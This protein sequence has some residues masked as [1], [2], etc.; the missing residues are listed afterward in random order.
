MSEVLVCPKCKIAL[1][2]KGKS[3]CCDNCRLECALVDGIYDF[4]GD[5]GPY[6]GEIPPEEMEETLRCATLKGWRAAA[7]ELGFKYPGRNEYILSNARIDWLFHCLDFTK[8]K[9]CLDLGSGW[10]T[11]AFGLARYYDEVWSLE[12]VRERIAFQRIRQQQDRI[13][14]IRFVRADWLRLPF[15]DNH[16]DL[17]VANGVLEWVGLSDYSRDPREVQADFLREVKRVLKPGGCLYLGTENRFGL[18][19]LMGGRDHSGLPFTSLLPRKLANLAVKL[20]GKAGEYRQWARMEKWTDYRTYTYSFWGYQKMLKE[21]GFDHVAPY[22]TLSYNNPKYAGKFDGESFAFLLRLLAKNTRGV[23]DAKS[24]LVFL[25]AHLPKWVIRL[26][27]PLIC[28]SFLIYAY[29]EER[30]KPFESELLR[31]GEPISSYMKVGG[32]HSTTSKITYFLLK[33]GNPYSVLKFPRFKAGVPYLDKEEARMAQFNRLEIGKE[34][35]GPVTV[36]VEPPISGIRPRPH[37]ISHSRKVLGW[38]L[39]FQHKTQQGYWNFES[40]EAR[41]RVLRDFLSRVP[42]SHEVRARAK[43]RIELFA[44]RLQQ[45]RLPVTAEHGDLSPANT[46][47][48][49]D[50]RVYVMD[51]EFYQEQGEP[52]FDFVF[53]FCIHSPGAMSKTLPGQPG[54]KGRYSSILETLISEFAKGNGLP[55]ELILDAVPYVILRCLY[56]ATAETDNKHLDITRYLRLFDLWDKVYL[57]NSAAYTRHTSNSPVE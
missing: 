40:L 27:L 10:G 34:V 12:A 47:I 38:L 52:L 2:R 43:Q 13:D 23:K 25:G 14:N 45:V 19:F 53:F 16:F 9:S 54:A 18:P 6:W 4:I 50:G 32:S 36:F 41:I 37:N 11:I 20:W 56:R 31:L 39:D 33:C 24:I 46:L 21:A 30:Q 49:D 55:P 29:K 51:W 3:F 15:P 7:T 8:T 1:T 17:V 28:P 22:W 57:H 48:G 26:G 5:R 42:I 44:K 35:I